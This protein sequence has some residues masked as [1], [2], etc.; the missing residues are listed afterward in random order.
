[1]SLSE[2]C[3][4]IINYR[5]E[6]KLPLYN[7]RPKPNNKEPPTFLIEQLVKYS[8]HHNTNNQTGFDSIIRNKFS[9]SIYKT[10]G[11][12]IGNGLSELIFSIQ[13]SFDGI[14]FHITPIPTI[15]REQIAT[16]GK[17]NHVIEIHTTI[18]TGWKVT[19]NDLENILS[20]YKQYQKMIIINNPHYPTG[21]IYNPDELLALAKVLS[22][23]NVIILSDESYHN[24]NHFNEII[25]I[26][27]YAPHLTIRGTSISKDI[28][29]EAYRLGWVTFPIEL[30][31]FYKTCNKNA[32]AIYNC[33]AIPIQYAVADLYKQEVILNNHYRLMNIIYQWTME[34]IGLIL[35]RT[36]LKFIKPMGGWHILLDFSHYRNK[37]EV[38]NGVDLC[39]FLL[40]RYGI[41][42]VPGE[43]YGIGGLNICL[44]FTELE[45]DKHITL[46]NI[47]YNLDTIIMSITM[48]IAI[49]T[50]FLNNL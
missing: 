20:V 15:Y 11:I 44:A 18:N 30:N 9:T 50:N 22:K 12:I 28:S 13:L 47:Q 34:K 32:K 25:S 39:E 40:N 24:V 27:E 5:C 21:I 43:N 19:P 23:H 1:M 17:S 46:D 49:L 36:K 37:L 3:L 35:R 7:F 38:T 16:L 2:E 6:H 29:G 45:I 14:I 31:Y 26:S 33:P 42:S 10:N 48:G 8:D 41:I 4:R